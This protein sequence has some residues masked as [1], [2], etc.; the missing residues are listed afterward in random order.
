MTLLLLLNACVRG[1]AH[2]PA[3]A[4]LAFAVEAGD[5]VLHSHAPVFFVEGHHESYNL[6]GTPVAR[7]ADNNRE[8]VYV[9]PSQ[10]TVYAETRDFQTAKGRYQNLIYRVHFEQVPPG[11]LGSG[12]N[13]GL[14][15]VVTLDQ[16]ANP[17]LYTTA[18]TCG[19][20][21]AMVPTSLLPD[22]ALPA[23]FDRQA[24]QWI[25][26]ESLP[27]HL[28]FDPLDTAATRLGLLIRAETHRVKDLWLQPPAHLPPYRISPLSLQPLAA[29]EQ[30]PFVQ[31]GATSFYEVTGRRAG[32]VKGSQKIWERLL[33]SWWALDW[34]VGEDK[35]LGRDRNEGVS[36]YTSLKPWARDH[37]DMRDFA[38]FL[39]YWGWNL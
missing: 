20:Y 8:V 21:L 4:E 34:F 17:L 18:L 13:V 32:Y 15:V 31:G 28:T 27:G 5:S 10:A 9:D 39:S 36:F 1:P 14:I 38:T 19:C 25:Y 11:H 22:E 12:R 26:G 35:K 2:L 6:I 7:L 30:L 37:S 16:Q 24:R 33:I 23:E 3:T 29:L